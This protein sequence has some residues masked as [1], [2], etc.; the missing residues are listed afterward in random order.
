MKVAYLSRTEMTDVDF[1]YLHYAKE[2]MDITYYLEITPRYLKGAAVNLNKT[3]PCCGIFNHNI[4]PEL[5]QFEGII[6]FSKFRIVNTC[7]KNWNINALWTNVK[8]F[9]ELKHKKYDVIHITWPLN[10]YELILYCFRNKMVITVHDPIV[11][12]SNSSFPSKLRRW[13]AFHFLKNFIILNKTQKDVFADTY[14]LH[15][16]KI[17]V[18][19]LSCYSYLKTIAEKKRV[20]EGKYIIFFGKISA[21][22]GLEYLFPAFEKVIENHPDT[23]LV[24]AGGG[25]YYFDIINY[26]SQKQFKII[27]RFIPDSELAALIRDS[28]F[29]VCP[30]KDATQSGVAMSAFAFDKPV[31][32]TNVGGLPEMLGN[33]KYGILV[34]PC[35]ITALSE[36]MD[37]LLNE[38]SL[39]KLFS[40]NIHSDYVNGDN[41]WTNVCKEHS[42]IYSLVAYS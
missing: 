2:V 17:H 14:G 32:S 7:G 24:V 25:N 23:S 42:D 34:P 15:N 11:H 41:S 10:F 16:K 1:S 40:D 13:F 27:N 9:K 28:E 21:Y 39:N 12:S 22:K 26:K 3:Y 19:R 29:T 30:Y 33:G 36:A 8:L 37:K 31:I 6:D 5:K 18:S 38:L 20:I 35:D 4:Y